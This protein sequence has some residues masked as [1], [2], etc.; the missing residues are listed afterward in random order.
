MQIGWSGKKEWLPKRSVA[1]AIKKEEKQASTI[2][3]SA[4]T[5]PKDTAPT[6]H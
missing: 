4:K 3:T 5:T 2:E 6:C 1:A